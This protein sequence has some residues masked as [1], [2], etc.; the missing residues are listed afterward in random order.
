MKTAKTPKLL[1]LTLFC[2]VLFGASHMRADVVETTNGARQ[3]GK[4]TSIH[5]G[6]VTIE[7][8]YAGKIEVKQALVISITTD[9]PVAVRLADGTD[10]IGIVTSPAPRKL[11]IA[12]PTHSVECAV[13]NV[14]ASWAAG[15]EDPDVIARRRKWTYE[16]GADVNGRTGTDRQ[17]ATS[18]H[19]RAKLAGP[20]D[21]FEY[22]TSYTRQSVNNEVSA[23]Q[24]KVGVDYSDNFTKNES[25]YV[26]DEAG[27]DRVN[28]ITLY[29]LAASG[30][31]YDFIKRKDETF[32]G[33]VG[34]SY[35]YDQYAS[36]KGSPLSSAGA[37]FGLGYTKKFK[38]SQVSDKISYDPTFQDPGNYVFNHEF[39]FE[40]PIYKSL[41]KLG[42]G[43]ANNYYSK[44]VGGVD[45]L[46]TLYFT[47][48]ILTWGSQPQDN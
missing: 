35:R 5:D 2:A 16:V 11:S 43:V 32:T 44:P 48:L 39:N 41:W 13:S 45:K 34:L 6:V 27:F 25:W 22:Y 29:D 37:D 18:Y 46:E 9:R 38:S 28:F 33:R 7:T 36:G 15:Q 30:L 20:D 10:V 8:E 4:I 40:I 14:S 19:Y 17:L 31:G 42:T 12:N 21:T 47:R 3:V 23:D 24:F 26:K 1:A